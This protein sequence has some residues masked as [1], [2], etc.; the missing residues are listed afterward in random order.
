MPSCRD[1]TEHVVVFIVDKMCLAISE[2]AVNLA[3]ARLFSIGSHFHC[4]S[5]IYMYMYCRLYYKFKC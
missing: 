4:L 1:S 3:I 5:I 2:A